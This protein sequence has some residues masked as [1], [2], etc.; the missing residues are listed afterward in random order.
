MDNIQGTIYVIDQDSPFV[1]AS[2]LLPSIEIRVQCERAIGIGLSTA[3]GQRLTNG[4]NGITKTLTYMPSEPE[5]TVIF[6]ADGSPLAMNVVYIYTESDCGT[7]K[8]A[9]LT[10]MSG[11]GLV[12]ENFDGRGVIIESGVS[13]VIVADRPAGPAFYHRELYDGL[14]MERLVRPYSVNVTYEPRS[15]LRV[16]ITA[17][18][19][20][21][22]IPFSWTKF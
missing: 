1:T 17:W 5:T 10:L 22:A 4:W 11:G 13:R 9:L 7:G 21:L 16:A 2:D 8:A 19:G 20:T 15:D 3:L 14:P 6:V 12:D 18:A